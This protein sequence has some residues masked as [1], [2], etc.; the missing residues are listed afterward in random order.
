MNGR[1]L[2]STYT[3]LSVNYENL[4]MSGKRKIIVEE[5]VKI[6]PTKR[7]FDIDFYLSLTSIKLTQ[8][9]SLRPRLRILFK[10]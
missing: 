10:N 8:M 1:K 4:E 5:S 9:A 2:F 6:L 7:P 3:I